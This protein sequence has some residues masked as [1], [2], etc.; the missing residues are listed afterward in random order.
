MKSINLRW[1]LPLA[2][3]ASAC[4]TT[5]SDHGGSFNSA[6]DEWS[7][8]R[9]AQLPFVD[10]S[11]DIYVGRD[12]EETDALQIEPAIPLWSDAKPLLDPASPGPGQD[13]K[14]RF[15]GSQDRGLYFSLEREEDGLWLATYILRTAWQ[16]EPPIA[17]P[18]DEHQVIWLIGHTGPGP[19][20]LSLPEDMDPGKW[21]VC[22]LGS[23]PPVCA[24]FGF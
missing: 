22:I 1:V 19:D 10:L 17:W 8:Q 24:N 2:I 14:I 20:F 23:D 16:G 9:D 7:E 15:P 5:T 21:R 13:F 11:S 12:S 18:A 4:S 3:F 6:S